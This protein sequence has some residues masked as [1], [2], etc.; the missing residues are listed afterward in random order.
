MRSYSNVYMKPS[1]NMQP[2]FHGEIIPNCRADKPVALR[3]L[4]VIPNFIAELTNQSLDAASLRSEGNHWM[5]MLIPP[6]SWWKL[7][8]PL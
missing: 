8:D 4:E 6:E 2:L 1:I 7:V 3:G 5:M